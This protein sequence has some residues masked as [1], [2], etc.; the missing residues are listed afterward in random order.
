MENYLRSSGAERT[1]Q[2]PFTRERLIELTDDLINAGMENIDHLLASA[3][4]K[5][6]S[7][8]FC[9]STGGMCKMPYIQQR[10]IERF[11][12]ARFKHTPDSDQLIA[13]GA[14]WVAYDRRGLTLTKPIELLHAD[15][16]YV[17]LLPAKTP[18]PVQGQE[19]IQPNFGLYSVDPRDGIAKIQ[20]C[21]PARPGRTLPSDPRKPYA[22]LSLKTDSTAAPFFERLYLDLSID[23][24]LIVHARARSGLVA[25]EQR[26]EI[27][28]SSSSGSQ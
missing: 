10:L 21:R 19:I 22:T 15:N 17:T 13:K 25:D 27:A 23:Q 9:L 24:D 14:A 7:I 28:G 12:L 11:G 2:V 16:T 6:V 1:L 26:T 5:D 3:G 18:L 20:L 4:Y 8:E